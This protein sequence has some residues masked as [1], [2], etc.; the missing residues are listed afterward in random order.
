M[1][2]ASDSWWWACAC[3]GRTNRKRQQLWP[4]LD[5]FLATVGS[6]VMKVLLVDRGFI[7]GAEIGRLESDH[8]IDTV[9]PIRS[10]INLQE[11]VRGLMKLS[12][13]CEEYEPTHRPPLPDPTQASHGQPPHPAAKEGNRREWH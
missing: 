3:C 10:D 2:P 9:I 1:R 7:N 8:G 4:L 6:G 11:D 13:T 12:T 5:T